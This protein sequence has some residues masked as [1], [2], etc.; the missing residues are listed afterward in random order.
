MVTPYFKTLRE[1][2]K[3]KVL[4]SNPYRG[5]NTVI[6]FVKVDQRATKNLTNSLLPRPQLHGGR[7]CRRIQLLRDRDVAD[8]LRRL[9]GRCAAILHLRQGARPP[10]PAC[11]KEDRQGA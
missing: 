10:R 11:P 1:S 9:R 5:S 7:M 4:F 6:D 8:H 2:F 3:K